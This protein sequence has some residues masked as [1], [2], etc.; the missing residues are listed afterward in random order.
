MIEPRGLAIE[1]Y[2]FGSA[3]ASPGSHLILCGCHRGKEN[4]LK[5][6]ITLVG[7]AAVVSL[8]AVASSQAAVV[9]HDNNV[10]VSFAILNPCNAE[11]VPLTG[12]EDT[13]IKMTTSGSGRVDFSEHVVIDVS[14]VGA[15]GTHYD[16][17]QVANFHENNV[18][19]VNGALTL[20]ETQTL[21]INGHRS[22]PNFVVHAVEHETITTDGTITSSTSDLTSECKD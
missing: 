22:A 10:P 14:G 20:T 9:T 19:F 3:L 12:T 4:K 2:G 16:L 8:T 11:V 18:T 17:L 21:H 5:K 13:L 15:S 1:D 6:L 7:L